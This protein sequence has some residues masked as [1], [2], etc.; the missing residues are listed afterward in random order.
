MEIEF[1]FTTKCQKLN[2]INNKNKFEKWRNIK[3]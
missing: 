3:G 2:S 1:Q